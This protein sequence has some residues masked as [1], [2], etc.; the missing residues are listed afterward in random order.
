VGF[1]KIAFGCALLALATSAVRA[2]DSDHPHWKPG[3][4]TIAKV[5]FAF[6]NAG[7]W[8][9]SPPDIAG[10]DRYY[11]GITIKGRHMVSAEFAQALTDCIADQDKRVHSVP[12]VCLA[13]PRKGEVYV[14]PE[15]RFPSAKGG[16]CSFV[17]LLYDVDAERM[18][19]LACNAPA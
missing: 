12:S 3:K 19:Q 8:H 14:V 4:T 9:G 13:K 10:Y 2:V 6:R 15:E 1:L 7:R 5:D 11:A 16:G 18:I 17:Y